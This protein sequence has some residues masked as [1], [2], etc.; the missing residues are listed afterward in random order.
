MSVLPPQLITALLAALPVT[1]LRA[2]LPIAVGSFGLEAA[3]A[4]VWAV[5]GNLLPVPFLLWL[6][7]PTTRWVSSHWPWAHRVLESYFHRLVNRHGKR[8]ERAG[9]LAVAAFVAIP[10][11]GTG[12]WTACV[13]A[14]LFGIRPRYAVP[15]VIGGVLIAGLVVLLITNGALGAFSWIL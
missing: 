7:P 2:A 5:V 9:M 13:L 6:L 3:D 1:E 12:A 8:F 14:V 11:P 10:L 4:Y 15:G